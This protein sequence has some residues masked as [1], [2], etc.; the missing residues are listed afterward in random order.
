MAH[1]RIRRVGHA[2]GGSLGLAVLVV[3]AGVPAF[4]GQAETQVAPRLGAATG[5]L[6]ST[7]QAGR[8]VDVPT[9]VAVLAFANITG[10]PADDWMGAGIAETV[11]V[12]AFQ[13]N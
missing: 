2:R 3:V 9:S 4:A 6:L 10:D 8:G 12:A 11:I 1:A 7:V 13:E 5:Q